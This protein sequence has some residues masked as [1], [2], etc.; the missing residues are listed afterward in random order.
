MR[1]VRR[2]QFGVLSPHEIKRMSVVEGGIRYAEVM[3][4]G[5]PK[6]GG[7][8]DPRQGC[9]DRQSR[10]QT[11]ACNQVDCP[12]HFA[13]IELSKPVFHPGFLTKSVKVLRCVC[14]FCSKLLIDQTHP[15]V[16]EILSK[17][18]GYP[19]KRLAHIYDLCRGKKICEGG[20]EMDQTF[21]ADLAKREGEAPEP[22]A[23]G[24]GGCGRYQPQIRRTGLDLTAEWK[25]VN[26]DTQERKINLTA[27]RVHE[28]FKRISDEES[29]I[30][31]M[32]QKYTRPDW[33]IITVLP[34]PPLC[35]RPAV[36][37]FGSARNQVHL[38]KKLNQ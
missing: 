4:G 33:M 8:M 36:V 38:G 7:L 31:G 32:D 3:E 9:V 35:V 22:R 25:H 10:C 2:V 26:E 19:R 23:Q 17:S 5:K 37:M 21:N 30:L 18:K 11:C 27:E 12:G 13:H 15:K 16:K 14:F 28:I 1:D 29:S 24:H 6:L 20:E 34:V